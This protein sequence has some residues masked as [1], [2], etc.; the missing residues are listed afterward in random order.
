[1]LKRARSPEIVFR[2]FAEFTAG[3][4]LVA[5]NASFDLSF[6]EAELALIGIVRVHNSLC[7]LQLSKRAFP[8]AP[9]RKLAS[10]AAYAGLPAA[11]KCH[12]AL[13]DATMTAQLFVRMAGMLEIKTGVL[14]EE[15]E[16]PSNDVN[17]SS[18]DEKMAKQFDNPLQALNTKAPERVTAVDQARA[19]DR[20]EVVNFST[21]AAQVREMTPRTL[22]ASALDDAITLIE[23][24]QGECARQLDELT[25]KGDELA[26]KEKEL[27]EREKALG[28]QLRAVNLALKGNDPVV[29]Q[30]IDKWIEE[31]TERENSL[32]VR[33]AEFA[34]IKGRAVKEG[35]HRTVG[36]SPKVP[37]WYRWRRLWI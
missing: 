12:R 4:L 9:N 24:L 13:A 20:K 2:E 33:E 18:S 31:F 22:T 17:V 37:W 30:K 1:M 23:Y 8:N 11:D 32:K 7:T 19:D 3:A 15:A 10:L 29:K 35:L 27:I 14:R 25:Q 5:H 28:V 6:V 21:I 16:Q 26:T 34:R 36:A